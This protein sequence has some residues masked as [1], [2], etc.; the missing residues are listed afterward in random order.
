M[1]KTKPKETVISF[2][3]PDDLYKKITKFAEDEQRTISNALR[4]LLES[5]LDAKS[6]K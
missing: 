6:K 4:L 3:L 2:R 5:A 1:K